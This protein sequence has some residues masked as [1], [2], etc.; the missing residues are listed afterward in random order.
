MGADAAPRQHVG[1]G[2]GSDGRRY[3]YAGRPQAFGDMMGRVA[4]AEHQEL[5]E[6][7]TSTLSYDG[8]GTD[9]NWQLITAP[10]GRAEALAE[11]HPPC[12]SQNKVAILS[13]PFTVPS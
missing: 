3:L 11:Y 2:P 7:G 5:H 6:D 8:I 9:C 10:Q 1:L 13:Y 4:E 12:R